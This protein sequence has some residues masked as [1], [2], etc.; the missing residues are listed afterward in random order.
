MRVSGS[1]IHTCLL[2]GPA[3]RMR[4]LGVERSDFGARL[5]AGFLLFLTGFQS[6][7][8]G[9]QYANRANVLVRHCNGSG[10]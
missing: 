7:I 3:A 8:W 5:A 2:E 10:R 6:Y 1:Y 9:A 4:T